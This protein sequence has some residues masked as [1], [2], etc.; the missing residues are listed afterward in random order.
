[1]RST[2]LSSS[3][4]QWWIWK[5]Q[6]RSVSYTYIVRFIPLRHVFRLH[7]KYVYAE[8]LLY[9]FLRAWLSHH[10]LHFI[11]KRYVS[12][13]WANRTDH[14]SNLRSTETELFNSA[15]P[16]KKMIISSFGM[17]VC[18]SHVS[19]RPIGI[20]FCAYV[21]NVR[22]RKTPILDLRH[23]C[24]SNNRACRWMRTCCPSRHTAPQ[25]Y[26]IVYIR[27]VHVRDI[28]SQPIIFVVGVWPNKTSSVLT[29]VVN[30]KIVFFFC[31]DT[32]H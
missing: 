27:R 17:W 16:P 6:T 3:P 32:L 15:L 29:I 18:E 31:K 26:T 12:A 14:H 9:P 24:H 5:S 11:A 30:D 8:P 21:S 23:E 7:K 10:K 19:R 2:K 25:G 13:L 4:I 22:L 28:C 1:M 20:T